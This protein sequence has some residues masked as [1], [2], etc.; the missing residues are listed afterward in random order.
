MTVESNN[1]LCM[2]TSKGDTIIIVTNGETVTLHAG[3]PSPPG[4][5]LK[6]R[7]QADREASPNALTASPWHEL[8]VKVH[9]CRALDPNAAP[10]VYEITGRWVNL[11]KEARAL[12]TRPS[13]VPA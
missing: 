3:F 10:R 8:H 1:A 13:F 12:L 6:G 11:S 7:I 9:G 5:P 2:V 4:S